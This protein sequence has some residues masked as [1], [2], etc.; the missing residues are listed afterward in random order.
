MVLPSPQAFLVK[1]EM[2]SKG[3]LQMIEDV[4][5]DFSGYYTSFLESLSS[6][7]FFSNP[8]E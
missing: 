4:M 2:L 1:E 6:A 7:S 3:A 5:S 8:D